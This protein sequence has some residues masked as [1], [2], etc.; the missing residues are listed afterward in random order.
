MATDKNLS[1]GDDVSWN[2]AQGKTHGE[3]K[4]RIT[5]DTTIK[6]YDVKASKDNP[7][8]IVESDKTGNEAAHT[9]DALEK[10]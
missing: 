1:K 4:K 8:Y 7:K 9:P 10:E 5:S 2:T 6:D 3:V